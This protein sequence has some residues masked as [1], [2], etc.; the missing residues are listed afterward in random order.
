MPD[1][2]LTLSEELKARLLRRAQES[3]YATVEQYAQAVLQASAADEVVDDEELESL[4]LERLEDPQPGIELTPHF[5]QQF[6]DELQ[7]R[8]TSAGN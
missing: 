8:R 4:L 7:R 2:H 3:G 5:K 6:R 1:L